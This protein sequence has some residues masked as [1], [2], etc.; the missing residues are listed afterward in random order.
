MA[1]Y[2]VDGTHV[3]DKVRY[4]DGCVWLND[5]QHFAAVPAVAWGFYIG[6]YQPAQKWLKDRKGRALTLED[7][8]HY[9]R[10]IATLTETHRVMGEVNRVYEGE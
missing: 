6:G 9:Q 1:A 3:V 8:T 7:I 2:P 5:T 10:I 4:E